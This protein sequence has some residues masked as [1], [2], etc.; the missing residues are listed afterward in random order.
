MQ[1][2]GRK[3]SSCYTCSTPQRA[4]GKAD[5]WAVLSLQAHLLLP[6]GQAP[7]RE[8]IPSAAAF[9]WS[10]TGKRGPEVTLSL[11]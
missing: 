7:F 10:E 2:K 6:P 4:Q 3:M 11:N 8:L 9:P 1:W 5:I